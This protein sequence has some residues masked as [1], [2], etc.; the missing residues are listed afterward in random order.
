MLRSSAAM[1]PG[2]ATISKSSPKW[3]AHCQCV[4]STIWSV[5][6]LLCQLGSL[7]SCVDAR[8]TPSGSSCASV[9]STKSEAAERSNVRSG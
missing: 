8:R 7:A 6:L 2:S 3:P 5:P 4:Q 1:R 9:G